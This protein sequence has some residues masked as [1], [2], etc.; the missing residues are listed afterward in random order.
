MFLYFAI[1]REFSNS[2]SLIYSYNS[3]LELVKEIFA[4]CVINS[5]RMDYIKALWAKI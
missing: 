1:P 5:V 2:P 4:H 3:Q